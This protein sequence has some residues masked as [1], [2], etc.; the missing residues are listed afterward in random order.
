MRIAHL[1]WS[2]DYGG[3]ETMLVDIINEQLKS[4]DVRLYIINDYYNKELLQTLDP[5]VKVIL[6]RRK[7]GS[8]NIISLAKLN[9]FLLSF[10]PDLI[11]CH[12]GNLIGTLWF[13]WR[14]VLTIHNTHC[15]SKYF[16]RYQ[17]L[18]CI[19][20]A[21]KDYAA[22]Q[23][24]PNGRVIYNGIHTNDIEIKDTSEIAKINTYKIVCVGRL[25]PE[26]G[27]RLVID[28]LN[29]LVNSRHL[30]NIT[31]DL[32]GDGDDRAELE[33]M[34]AQYH[35]TEHIKFVGFKSREWVYSHLKDYD[36]FVMPSISEGFGLTLAE[37]CAAKLPVVTSDLEGPLEV[38][39]GGR[40]GVIFK[41]GDSMDLAD[42][43]YQF[44]I[45]PIDK[46]IVDE[47]FN[48]SKT[49]FDVTQTA[50][51]YICQ[52]KELLNSQNNGSR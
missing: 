44:I 51:Q 41:H 2:F 8:K 31:C 6:V 49:H 26:K 48:F 28:A 25:H 13:P 10:S 52:Y 11:H 46:S 47:A 22:S 21:V 32:I 33:K 27:Q 5:K 29:D 36:I 9:I 17:R 30:T 7:P 50:Q 18:F 24:F 23:G 39:A 12:Q 19:S 3:V 42:K 15:P 1:T 20:E 38:I 35:L 45:N 40:L 14:K 37:A 4:C 34:V 16:S 43:L